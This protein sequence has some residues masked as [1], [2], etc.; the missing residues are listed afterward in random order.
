MMSTPFSMTS[1]I[2]ATLKTHTV[3]KRVTSVIPYLS[4]R[5]QL[6]LPKGL[7]PLLVKTPADIHMVKKALT[8]GRLLGIIQPLKETKT[9]KQLYRVGCVG[10]I[11]TFSENEDGSLYIV[12]KGIKRFS[13]LAEQS[14]ILKVDY[15][16]YIHDKTSFKKTTSKKRPYLVE[17]LKSYL[18]RLSMDIN[19]KDI[20]NADDESLT[21]SLA[22]MCP[23]DA[24]EKQAILESVSLDE[25]FEMLT[26][27]I[28]MSEI[29]Q[30]PHS[31][32]T[33]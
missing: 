12:L 18:S 16:P 14:S 3:S 31:W 2:K 27:F 21:T 8:Q 26:A 5:G 28:E 10:R 11:T 22:M 6:L 24:T 1:L 29:Q 33:H 25:R 15:T 4:K 30:S 13:A 23:F 9:Q 7:L 19:W 20:T 32:K 17:I